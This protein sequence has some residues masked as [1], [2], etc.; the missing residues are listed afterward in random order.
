MSDI[1]WLDTII[2]ARSNYC[3]RRIIRGMMLEMGLNIIRM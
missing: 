1:K 2:E 3:G